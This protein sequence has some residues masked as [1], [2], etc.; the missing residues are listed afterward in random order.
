[1]STR[2]VIFKI[3]SNKTGKFFIGHRTLNEEEGIADVL[4]SEFKSGTHDPIIPV[5]EFRGPEGYFSVVLLTINSPRFPYHRLGFHMAQRV[6]QYQ[7]DP[8]FLGSTMEQ[9]T[10]LQEEEHANAK[11]N[12]VWKEEKN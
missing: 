2:L 8:L 4:L 7:F 6:T 11:R 1:M 10:K 5:E 9:V 12:V 3:I